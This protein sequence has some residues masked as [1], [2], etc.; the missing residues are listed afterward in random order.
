M[1]RPEAAEASTG[2]AEIYFGGGAIQ[3]LMAKEM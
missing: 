1:K 3:Q 2:R